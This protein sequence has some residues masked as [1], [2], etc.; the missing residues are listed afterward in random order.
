MISTSHNAK[1][2]DE[3]DRKDDGLDEM[4]KEKEEQ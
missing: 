4:K 2:N 3:E 1:D